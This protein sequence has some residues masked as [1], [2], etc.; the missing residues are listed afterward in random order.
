[1]QECVSEFISF[2][3][4]EYPT[5]SYTNHHY[6]LNFAESCSGPFPFPNLHADVDLDIGAQNKDARTFL[7]DRLQYFDWPLF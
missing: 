1:M 2:I 6:V 5:Y 4:S 3:T 7:S